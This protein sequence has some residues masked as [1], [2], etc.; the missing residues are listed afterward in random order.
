MTRAKRAA[1]TTPSAEALTR[2]R[3][4]PRLESALDL[5]AR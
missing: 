5:M 1:A 4:C 2:I 3:S